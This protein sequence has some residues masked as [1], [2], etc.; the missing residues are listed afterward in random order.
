MTSHLCEPHSDGDAGA[1]SRKPYP[2]GSLSSR[3]GRERERHAERCSRDQTAEMCRIVDAALP[4]PVQQVVE[5]ERRNARRPLGECR[6]RRRL[7]A[8][9]PRGDQRS[10]DSEYC[11]R[12]A[13]PDDQR[14]DQQARRAPGDSAEE[15]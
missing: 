7:M 11:P 4:E 13:G 12:R 5:D 14:V 9:R 8:P 10:G 2:Q 3:R 1:H 6:E 15:I